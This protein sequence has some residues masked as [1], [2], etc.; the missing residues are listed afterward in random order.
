[1][2]SPMFGKKLCAIEVLCMH[3]S[4]IGCAWPYVPHLTWWDSELGLRS[5]R[6]GCNCWLS[7]IALWE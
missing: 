1:M 7:I 4:T 2:M 5:I 3:L 6:Q